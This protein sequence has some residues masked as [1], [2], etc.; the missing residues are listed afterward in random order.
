M[1]NLIL[2]I[3]CSASIAIILKIN[4]TRNGD[5]IIL[6]TGNYFAASIISLLLFL[7]DGNS[8]ASINL[9]PLGMFLSLLFVGSIFAFSKSVTLSGAALSTVSSRLSVFVPIILSLVF[10]D[11]L[12][13][14]FQ[15]IGL[16]LTLLTIILFYL[17][18]NNSK[19]GSTNKNVFKYLLLILFGIGIADFFMKV[20]QE[21]WESSDKPWFL[22]W[23]FFSSLLITLL[24]ILREKK[25]LDKRTMF[26]GMA[27]GI[28]NIFSSYFLIESLKSFDA[29]FVYP[30]VN[31]SIIIITAVIVKVFWKEVWN[32]YSKL[33]LLSGIFSILL[34]SL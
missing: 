15:I 10:Y 33:A 1:I 32:T 17:S 28:P 12:P 19:K 13:N 34:L 3:F 8:T 11:E 29:V 30:I 20:F 4:S 31:I 14:S 9:I 2:T 22:F 16:A 25:Q 6:L 26:W 24:I 18:I 7:S 21:N 5:S 27:M 23:I